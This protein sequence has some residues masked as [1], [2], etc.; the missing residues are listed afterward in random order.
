MLFKER[1]KKPLSLFINLIMMK[2]YFL[3]LVLL[4]LLFSCSPKKTE[5]H[6]GSFKAKDTLSFNVG[7]QTGNIKYTEQNGQEYLAFCEFIT[8]KQIKVFNL[9]KKLLYA[10]S[11]KPIMKKEKVSLIGFDFIA[12]DTLGLLSYHKNKV[13]II[14]NQ[15]DI[16][17][18]KDY[19]PLFLKNAM[20]F[21]P[22]DFKNNF[23]RTGVLYFNRNKQISYNEYNVNKLNFSRLMS[24]TNIYDSIPPSFQIDSIYP[25][26]MSNDELAHEGCNILMTDSLNIFYTAYSDSLYL[27]NLSGELKKIIAVKSDY[28]QPACV[29]AVTYERYLDDSDLPNRN[30]RTNGF[31]YD[32]LWDKY[33]QLYYC[34]V[35]DKMEGKLSPF[36]VIIYNKNFKK[37][38]EFKMNH[39][40]Y[41]PTT[42]VGLKGLY[43]KH[44]TT[45]HF[46]INTFTLFEY[47]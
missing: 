13:F 1:G 42:F 14:N 27:Y 28:V 29:K 7:F 24:D 18:K 19:T 40:Q 33:R 43:I 4:N 26:F 8:F 45:D 35:S 21:A 34:L 38:D 15:S 31:I 23:I 10:T 16:I 5:L 11:L 41:K 44:I 37:L 36:S 25:R 12:P 2:K 47:E 46:R 3:F 39:H 32:V 17:F 22:L 6:K 20:L 30:L 9:K